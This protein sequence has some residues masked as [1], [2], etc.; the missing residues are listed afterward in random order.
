MPAPCLL[1]F[2]LTD[3]K[4]KSF[5]KGALFPYFWAKIGLLDL[6]RKLFGAFKFYLELR[7]RS[8][9]SRQDEAVARGGAIVGAQVVGF[10]EG[11]KAQGVALRDGVERLARA[12]GVVGVAQ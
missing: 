2:S 12:D 3:V 1:L 10:V 5:A 8:F 6:K 4:R 9:L 7:P 11:I